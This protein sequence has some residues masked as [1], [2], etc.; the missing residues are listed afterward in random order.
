MFGYVVNHS[1]VG[2]R[3]NAIRPDDV[4]SLLQSQAASALKP[5][6][7]M[8]Q[9]LWSERQTTPPKKKVR[10]NADSS[11]LTDTRAT[12]TTEFNQPWIIMPTAI[13]HPRTEQTKTP[14]HTDFLDRQPNRSTQEQTV[15]KRKHTALS[16]DEH[17]N[18]DEMQS[19]LFDVL[20]P[21]EMILHGQEVEGP[22]VE[23]GEDSFLGEAVYGYVINPNNGQIVL[24]TKPQSS[25]SSSFASSTAASATASSTGTAAAA[26]PALPSPTT[27]SSGL[28]GGAKAGIAIGAVAGVAIIAGLA[29]LL[30]RERRKKKRVAESG[31]QQMGYNNTAYPN[32]YGNSS[33]ISGG[34]PMMQQHQQHQYQQPVQKD[35]RP[36]EMPP[37]ELG[38]NEGGGQKYQF[39]SEMGDGQGR[40][41]PQLGLRPFQDSIPLS[42]LAFSPSRSL[43]DGI[44][45]MA[46]T[47]LG[48]F[49]G[50]LSILS[51]LTTSS[52]ALHLPITPRASPPPS[53]SIADTSVSTLPDL[54]A[55]DFT[56]QKL[57]SQPLLPELACIMASITALQYLALLGP[58]SPVDPDQK[59]SHPEYPGVAISV[60]GIT[61]RGPLEARLAMLT[62]NAGI[63][64]M[65]KSTRYQSAFYQGFYRDRPVASVLFGP[66]VGGKNGDGFEPQDAAPL[67]PKDPA[68]TN[69]SDLLSFPRTGPGKADLQTGDK[70]G[71][72]VDY[73]PKTM[74]R[75]DAMA[76]IMWV[77]ISASSISTRPMGTFSCDAAGVTVDVRTIWNTLPAA[78]TLYTPTGG[79]L[80]NMLA[81]LAVIVLRDNR[82][83]EMNVAINDDGVVIARGLIRTKV[84]PPRTGKVASE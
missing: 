51:I 1:T 29:F 61:G 40:P 52:T 36:A 71:A 10:S 31:N 35:Y 48:Y 60:S 80:I 47:M 63:R 22:R 33:M 14:K 82:F 67:P 50:Y 66:V 55:A 78:R 74:D 18:N 42:R 77:I 81:M 34:N 20:H 83:A 24:Q 76:T 32:G 15:N 25:A 11:T 56:Y 72:N 45:V 9:R 46:A 69:R 26:A 38:A 73:L 17:D 37:S 8:V 19:A 21:S 84:R 16:D 2:C 68:T 4:E 3:R 41:R 54:P 6:N 70:L 57:L 27:T 39:H 7:H 79:D 43:G 53:N 28:S 64:D 75:R 49:L 12:P 59:W 23:T 44:S 58:D 5:K 13:Q 30:F 62:I 65:M